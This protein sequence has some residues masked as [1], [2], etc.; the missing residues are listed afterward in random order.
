MC[1]INVVKYK[2]FVFVLGAA[3]AGLAGLL[4]ATYNY[5]IE[6]KAFD[7]MEGVRILL[8]VVLGG[9]GSLSGTFIA[10]VKP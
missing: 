1:G 10:V 9:M 3:F 2:L 7:F 6:P 5:R 8:M 4:Y